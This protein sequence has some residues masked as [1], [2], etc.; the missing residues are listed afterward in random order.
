MDAP[1]PALSHSAGPFYPRTRKREGKP[2]Q[3][4]PGYAR[5]SGSDE[6]REQKK[7]S[8][9]KADVYRPDKNSSVI[10]GGSRRWNIS[11]ILKRRDLPGQMYYLT[12]GRWIR[13]MRASNIH[14]IV[15]KNLCEYK[16]GRHFLAD[17]RGTSRQKHF[18]SFCD[19]HTHRCVDLRV[20]GE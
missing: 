7:M 5:W 9:R 10:K 20:W 18:L 1:A 11:T 6:R 8:E 19:L 14:V 4:A 3:H 2:S 17:H 15:K 16:V 13:M 12:M